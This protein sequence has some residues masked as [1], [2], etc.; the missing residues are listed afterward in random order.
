MSI[1]RR[2]WIVFDGDNTL[3]ETE[4]LYD[5]ARHALCKLIAS[6]APTVREQDVA[7][8]QRRRD[9]ELHAE[10]GYS[11][12]RYP[13][14]F[15]ETADHFL[16][17]AHPRTEEARGLAERVFDMN[18]RAA[19]DVDSVLERL[20]RSFSISLLTA[21]ERSVQE[22]RIA[23]FGRSRFFSKIRIVPSKSAAVLREFL[24]YCGADAH[25]SWMV[26]DSLKSDIVP[27]SEIGMNS[28]WLKV[29][30]WHEVE[31]ADLV[32]PEKTHVARSLLDVRSIILKT[33]E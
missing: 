22:R 11:P 5:D 30:N 7:A 1:S 18:A 17:P 6:Q 25:L 10:M 15:A 4:R 16:G 24:L 9:H 2:N 31:I 23:S 19:Q 28:V 21:G 20:A 14:S 12:S 26:G 29:A 27:A 3:W 8:F 32:A 13:R 33:S